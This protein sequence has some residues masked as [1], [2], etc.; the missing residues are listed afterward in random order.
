MLMYCPYCGAPLRS[1]TSGY[2]CT[3][4]YC[5]RK[6]INSCKIG[7]CSNCGCHMKNTKSKEK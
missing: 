6:F 5:N 2:V 1:I 7:V 4:I 3:N